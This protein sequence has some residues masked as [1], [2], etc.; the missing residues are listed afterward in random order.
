[1]NLS[2]T[3]EERILFERLRELFASSL[4]LNMKL[5]AGQIL[6]KDAE[7]KFI[8]IAYEQIDIEKR[9]KAIDD[10]KKKAE[11]DS[12]QIHINI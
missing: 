11:I 7:E 12:A 4:D 5:M 10:E 9:L 1:M 3:K 8:K 2:T 6:K